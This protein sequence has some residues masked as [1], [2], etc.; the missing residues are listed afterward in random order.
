[1]DDDSEDEDRSQP[2]VLAEPQPRPCAHC[3]IY[4][5]E[6]ANSHEIRDCGYGSKLGDVPG[7]PL[8]N[9]MTH[10]YDGCRKRKRSPADRRH[11]DWKFL[12]EYRS[13][14]PPVRTKM[15]WPDLVTNMQPT[16]GFPITKDMALQVRDNHRHGTQYHDPLTRTLGD[17]RKNLER[18][19]AS[20][21]FTGMG[22]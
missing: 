16:H 21:V 3:Q 17:V 15:A 14:L 10:Y 13:G 11:E 8:C 6:D 1:M 20:E 7:C 19:R 4:G 2:L 12:V 9:R 5:R 18:L 22:C